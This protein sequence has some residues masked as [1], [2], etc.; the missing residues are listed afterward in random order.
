MDIPTIGRVVVL[1]ATAESQDLLVNLALEETVDGAIE[2]TLNSGDPYGTVLWPAAYAVATK[3]LEDSSYRSALPKQTVLELGA[4]TGLVSLAL[5]L[6]GAK[7]VIATDYEQITLQILEYAATH[8]NTL[9][10]LN[11]TNPITYQLLDMT[12]YN[13]PLPPVDLVVAADIMYEPKTGIAMARRAVEALRQGARVLVGDSPGRPGRGAFLEELRNLGVSNAVFVDAVGYT[14]SGPR[15]DLICGKD[16][17]SV[18]ET[19]RELLVAVMELEPNVH[20]H[21]S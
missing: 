21:V 13:N 20:L 4:G 1:E 17:Q 18:S 5:S 15:H 14:C 16:S 19:P 11:D 6:A 7:Q 3:I 12:D 2:T 9:E 10:K 8:L